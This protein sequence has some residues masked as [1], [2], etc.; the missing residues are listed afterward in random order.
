MNF[1]TDVA[2]DCVL[3]VQAEPATPLNF[4]ANSDDVTPIV[5][6]NESMQQALLQHLPPSLQNSEELINTLRSPQLQQALSA[7]T[8]ALQTDNLNA[9][10]ANFGLDPADGAS[11]LQ[12]GNGVQAMLDA[13]QAQNPPPE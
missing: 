11:A 12:R 6:Q 2:A 1:K 7:L 13:I 4:I 8:G 9:V 10:F 3:Q 5:S